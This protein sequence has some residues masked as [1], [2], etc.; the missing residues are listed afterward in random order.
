MLHF[1]DQ[2]SPQIHTV[3][4]EQFRQ[5]A[6]PPRIIYDHE[7]LLV[8]HGECETRFENESPIK[9]GAGGFIIKPCARPHSGVQTSHGALHLR[10]V[11]FDWVAREPLMTESVPR[12]C[13]FPGT[14]DASRYRHA[15]V[16]VPEEILHGPIPDPAGVFQAFDR[17]KERWRVGTARERAS[18]RALFLEILIDMLGEQTGYLQTPSGLRETNDADQLVGRMREILNRML[19]DATTARQPLEKT[20]CRLG[21]SYPHLCRVFK[22]SCGVSPLTYYN[23]M[24]ME[25]ARLLLRDTTHPVNEIALMTGFANPAYFSYLFSKYTGKSPRVYRTEG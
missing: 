14:P 2:I 21:Y 18:C 22:Q 15:P 10:W 23:S 7:L 5:W 25:R 24:R 11:H 3:D 8:E 19:G 6:G 20:L 13:Y 16:F 17:L 9:T 12:S 1:L 4:A